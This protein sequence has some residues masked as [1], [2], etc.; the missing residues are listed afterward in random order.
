[1]I[2]YPA[3]TTMTD[4]GCS[5]LKWDGRTLSLLDQRLLPSREFWVRCQTCRDVASAIKDMVV[6]GAPAI[7]VTAAYG[8][9][10]ARREE[11]MLEE[12]EA[13]LKN[14]RPTAVNLFWALKRMGEIW[15][16][17][18]GDEAR[19][20]QEADTIRKEDVAANRVMGR[21]GAE[22]IGSA[23]GVMTICNAGALAT[24]GYGTAL[25]VFRALWEKGER[26]MVFAPETR[27]YL[28]GSRL[29]AWELSR[30]GIP[31]TLITDNMV[32]WCM[33]KKVV[34][35]VVTGA[36][37]VASNG[38][39]ANKIGTYQMA[40][41]AQEHSIPFYVAAPI[42]TFDLTL[43]SGDRIPI[44]ERPPEEVFS[45][46]GVELAPSGVHAWH[47]A[48]DVTPADLIRAFF[49]DRGVLEPPYP[50][51]LARLL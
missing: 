28:Q 16:R 8:M 10:L 36:D 48:F 37:R 11:M 50:D 38:D 46:G 13:M 49:T 4:S 45:V 22:Y 39:T 5:P 25:G 19:L 9:V 44:E 26:F 24:A 20:E 43:T 31:V 17:T 12:A 3:M 14:T 7:G 40:I 1:M 18:G 34:D 41:L 15:Q 30:E 23:R 21:S 51:A 35:A 42:S 29:T 32:G 27:P 6:R 47:P 2:Q 33:K